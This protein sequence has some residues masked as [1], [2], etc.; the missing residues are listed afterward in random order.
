VKS[1]ICFA[2][3][4]LHACGAILVHDGRDAVALLRL[5]LGCKQHKRVACRMHANLEPFVGAFGQDAR[6]EG[7]EVFPVL[8][9]LIEDIAHLRPARIGEQ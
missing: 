5:D 9:L 2:A 8:D 7:A 3:H 6:R 1:R 4:E